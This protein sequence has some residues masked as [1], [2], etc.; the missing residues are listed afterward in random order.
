[1]E[2]VRFNQHRNTNPDLLTEAG[3]DMLRLPARTPIICLLM[4]ME[5]M[6]TAKLVKEQWKLV[7]DFFVKGNHSKDITLNYTN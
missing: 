7:Q 1:M 4:N 6:Q 3:D 5:G 2:L